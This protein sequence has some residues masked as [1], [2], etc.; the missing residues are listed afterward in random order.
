MNKYN[1]VYLYIYMPI[2]SIFT[3]YNAWP[4]LFDVFLML[5][6]YIMATIYVYPVSIIEYCLVDFTRSRFMFSYSLSFSVENYLLL[7]SHRNVQ[8]RLL[9]NVHWIKIFR[10]RKIFANVHIFYFQ[11]QRIQQQIQNPMSEE[12]WMMNVKS[13]SVSS[14]LFYFY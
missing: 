10:C 14:A 6:K 1:T 7:T 12:F 8:N 2:F 3:H 5:P 9:Y 11:Y 13:V 4:T